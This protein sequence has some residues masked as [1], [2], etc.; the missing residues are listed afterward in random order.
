[1]LFQ[2]IYLCR[3]HCLKIH[4]VRTQPAQ[5][6]SSRMVHSIIQR[7]RSPTVLFIMIQKNLLWIFTDILLYDFYCT[8]GR[9]VI[10][11]NQLP[12]LIFLTNNTGYCLFNIFF[13]IVCGHNH[14]D[15][16]LLHFTFLLILQQKPVSL[17]S[18]KTGSIF[19]MYCLIIV[20]ARVLHIL[21][22]VPMYLLHLIRNVP[23]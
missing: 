2:K 9:T 10:Y 19:L 20:T 18:H 17:V 16:F 11:N 7:H 8:I 12:I 3:D 1:M 6:F 5:I 15:Q 21:S 14:A 22:G 4:I 23:Q 13:C